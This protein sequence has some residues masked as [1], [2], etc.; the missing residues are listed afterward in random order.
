MMRVSLLH[1]TYRAG[2]LALATRDAWLDACESPERVEHIFACDLDDD[3]S[4]A[5][6][7]IAGGVVGEPMAGVTAVRNW[8][9][10]ARRA[11]G[12]LL[13]VI[14][15][16]LVP[17]PRWD[18]AVERI[19]GNRD[20]RRISFV[21]KVRDTPEDDS[22]LL[23]HPLVSRR[24]YQRFGLWCPLYQ[25]HFV[26]NDL[27]LST[28]RRGALIDGRQLTLHHHHWVHGAQPTESHEKMQLSHDAGE[29][30]FARRWPAWKQIVAR[31]GW[32]RLLKVKARQ[33]L[34]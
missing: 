22:M 13:F 2:P 18:S 30:L 19:V 24:Y 12:D 29:A 8:N 31:H 27:T 20:P 5:V 32:T 6:P 21:A 10:A 4:M 16:D 1:A 17:P 23:R 26:D 7:D 33:L 34:D 25:G 11:V 3:I 14:A 15:D 28:Q 9:A